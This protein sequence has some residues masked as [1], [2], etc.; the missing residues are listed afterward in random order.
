VWDTDD[1][2]LWSDRKAMLAFS[3]R[4]QTFWVVWLPFLLVWLWG[5]RYNPWTQVEAYGDL[6]EVIWGADWYVAHLSQ[7]RNPLFAPDIFYPTGWHTAAFSQS[8]G[9]LLPLGLLGLFLPNIAVYNGVML[10]A[11]IVAYLGMRRLLR[12]YVDEPW[13]IILVALLYTFWGFRW[14]RKGGQLNLIWLSSLLPWL[15]WILLREGAVRRKVLVAGILWGII[16]NF[17]LYGLWMGAAVLGVYWLAKPSLARI[18]Q[19][20]AVGVIAGLISLPGLWL[21]WQA[22]RA[23]D[24]PLYSFAEIVHWGSG[25]D[26]FLMPTLANPRW[27]PWVH[28]FYT[29]PGSEA[30]GA[31]YGPL[32]SL[33]AFV[34][35]WR[36][37]RA[38]PMQRFMLWLFLVGTLLA[39][40][41]VVRWGGAVVEAPSLA[42]LVQSLWQLGHW[43][44]PQIFSAAVHPS[45]IH[46]IP[47][48]TWLFYALIPFSEGARVA[49][50]FAFVGGVGVYG[51][52]A[53]G[54][55][56]LR[57][58]W[59]IALLV[60]LLLIEGLPWPAYGL[61]FPPATHPAF[62]WLAAQPSRNADA[63]LDVTVSARGFDLNISPGTLY[64]TTI[65]KKP[66]VSG[67][68]SLWPRSV[69]FWRDWLHQQG[70]PFRAPEL[71]TLL[72]TYGVHWIALHIEST[73]GERFAT[74]AYQ[75][76]L[77]LTRCFAP[78]KD[79]TGW[80]YPICLFEVQ[81]L[82]SKFTGMPR[83]GWSGS[84]AWG[85]WSEGLQST[86]E[87]VAPATQAYTLQVEAF[88]FCVPGLQ[89]QIELR[90]NGDLV[91][92]LSF[93]G[94][95]PLVQTF[96]IDKT[97]IQVGWNQLTLHA[98]YARSPAALTQ[99]Q[100]PDVRLLAAGFTRLTMLPN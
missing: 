22:N 3:K 35:I 80:L 16:V 63:V 45:L 61:P 44:K 24:A 81:A 77:K 50:R 73:A 6:L 99:G 54:L 76:L 49:S 17:T 87:W 19:V 62:T 96:T 26:N 65:H 55:T 53:V 67:A 51:L 46:A 56:R 88:P 92:L 13:L 27:Q 34:G 4:T 21:F 57:R 40:G 39:A 2:D 48:P 28:Y 38:D 97:S 68:G 30:S 71:S 5:M 25:I 58:R 1:A 91:G 70:D 83:N 95:D 32:V 66:I 69:W 7:F 78:V 36:L 89:Q 98:A 43:L 29:G 79:A 59:L 94:C 9:L 42:P 47:L 20:L 93:S 85:R 72:Q 52:V 12:L 86:V 11:F 41:P 84:E 10:A 23:A 60:G 15:V 37:K 18:Q 64:A 90:A 31:N 75:P 82:E 33:L 8:A 100:N 14:G 74:D